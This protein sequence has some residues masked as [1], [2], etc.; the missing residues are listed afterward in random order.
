MGDEPAERFRCTNTTLRQF[1]RLQSPVAFHKMPRLG[2]RQPQIARC[3]CPFAREP[4]EVFHHGVRDQRSNDLGSTFAKT[5]NH[6][7]IGDSTFLVRN[8]RVGTVKRNRDDVRRLARPRWHGQRRRFDRVGIDQ[9]VDGNCAVTARRRTQ[10]EV[11]QPHPRVEQPRL[12]PRQK[13]LRRSIGGNRH[14]AVLP[15]I[16]K[17]SLQHLGAS[18][19]GQFRNR[20]ALHIAAPGLANRPVFIEQA[21][22]PSQGR[23]DQYASVLRRC[24]ELRFWPPGCSSAHESSQ[25]GVGAKAGIANGMRPSVCSKTRR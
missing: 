15:R 10:N 7:Q 3:L 12:M 6:F 17:G 25:R 8:A 24:T 14:I 1:E 13:N 20:S 11:L 18:L 21:F 22:E 2:K 5:A 23:R 16:R 9:Q 19:P 4:P